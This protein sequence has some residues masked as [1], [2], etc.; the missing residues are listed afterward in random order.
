M[1]LALTLSPSCQ[2]DAE[3]QEAEA[4]PGML[5]IPGGEFSM[6][7]AGPEAMPEEQPVHRVRITGFWMDAAEVTNAEFRRFVE[8]TSYVTTAERPP[9]FDEE[10]GSLVFS[11]SPE[12]AS[13]AMEWWAWSPGTDWRHPEGPA[14]DL[15]GR[16]DHPVVHVSWYDA[17]A[18]AEWAGKRLATEAEWE[19]AARGG[20]EG[21][22]Y[23]WGEEMN[24]D[25]QTM[26]NVWQGEFPLENTLADGYASTSPVRSFAANGYGLYD[27]SGNVWEWCQNWYGT[28]DYR[29]QSAQ[30]PCVDPTGAETGRDASEPDVPKRVT[31]GGSFLCSDVYCTGYRPSARMKSTPD[32]SLVNTGFRCVMTPEMWAGHKGR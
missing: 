7:S 1:A 21:N 2:Q 31:R 27:M 18:Y 32:T 12:R 6:G 9:D 17:L 30:V 22:T 24:P 23:V 20:V 19:Y 3:G 4:P 16:D 25:G 29:R 28:D 15:S 26:A 14:S 11:P 5:W 8:A 10:P 13:G